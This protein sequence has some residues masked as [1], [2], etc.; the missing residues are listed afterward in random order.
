MG[1]YLYALTV[2]KG[3]FQAKP[4]MICSLLL[5]GG[6]GKERCS[7]LVFKDIPCHGV[8]GQAVV[9][10]PSAKISTG[11]YAPFASAPAPL[12]V[13]KIMLHCQLILFDQFSSESFQIRWPD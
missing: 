9:F 6:Q 5:A 7:F 1:A 8:K 3:A 12:A 2:Y 10:S 4:E 13:H 11:K